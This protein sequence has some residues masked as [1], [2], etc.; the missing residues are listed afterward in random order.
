MGEITTFVGL[1][2]HKA[3]IAVA[4]ARGGLRDA[5]DFLG[6]IENTPAALGKLLVKL[7][8][9]HDQL[10]FCYEA[11]PCGYGVHR[12]L[13]QA[14][15]TCS[16]VAPSLIPRRAGDRV[17]TDRRDAVSLAQLH[18][19]GE[20]SAIWVPDAAH[21][22]MRDLVRARLVAV[23]AVRRGRQQLSGFLLRHGRVYDGKKAWTRSYRIWLAGLRFEHAAQQ[24]VLQDYIAVVADSERRRD[25]LGEQIRVLLP[26]GQWRR[27]SRRCRR[28]AAWLWWSLPRWWPRSAT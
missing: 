26:N 14:G 5:A 8:R 20:L 27:W 3:T 16:V 10:S 9:K 24:I 4:V 17:K 19:A 21:E 15:H 23:H 7:G 2:V 28:C 1:D 22:A 11:G 18:R 12:Q 25:A 13:I 6:T